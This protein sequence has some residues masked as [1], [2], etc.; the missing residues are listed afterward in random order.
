M[1][2]I[3]SRNEYGC[4]S[5][6]RRDR[7]LFVCRS[8]GLACKQQGNDIYLLGYSLVGSTPNPNAERGPCMHC[9]TVDGQEHWFTPS[10][11]QSAVVEIQ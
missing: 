8:L 9:T 3:P 1:I 5:E 2:Y 11:K 10:S 6:K 4:R 7:R